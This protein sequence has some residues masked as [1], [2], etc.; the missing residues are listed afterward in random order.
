MKNVIYVGLLAG[1]LVSGCGE[2]GIPEE[3]D[4]NA[5][6]M[7][8]V[9]PDTIPEEKKQYIGERVAQMIF[10]S[11]AYVIPSEKFLKP[12]IKEFGDGT[13]V[14]KAMIKRV[15]DDVNAQ[16]A[17]YLVGLGW[18]N[19]N[20]R[21]MAFELNVDTENSLY[22]DKRSPKHIAEGTRCDFCYF[23]FISNKISGVECDAGDNPNGNCDYK[24]DGS[25]SMFEYKYTN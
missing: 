16:P 6:V 9:D 22:L 17:Y 24:T 5:I 2:K 4:P 8:G 11:V 20:F 18:N 25:N 19:G 1:I 10:D 14:D 12:F 13:V 3:S 15:N 21:A 7:E 23:T